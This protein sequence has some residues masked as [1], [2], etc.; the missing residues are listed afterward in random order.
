M[1]KFYVNVFI[2]AFFPFFL[3]AQTS[4]LQPDSTKYHHTDAIFQSLKKVCAADNNSNDLKL[5]F[6]FYHKN[7]L[8][9]TLQGAWT[10]GTTIYIREN[11]YDICKNSINPDGALALI[12]A[13]EMVHCIKKHTGQTII[14][15]TD[16]ANNITQE[17]L[18]ITQTHEEEADI[19]GYLYARIAGYAP[20]TD[21]K[22]IIEILYKKYN[23]P[24]KSPTHPPLQKRIALAMQDYAAAEE[25]YYQYEHGLIAYILSDY[26]TAVQNFH[27]IANT[28]KITAPEVLNNE[29]VGI[30]AALC[31]SKESA[32]YQQFLTNLQ[33]DSFLKNAKQH[34]TP[35][36]STRG[37]TEVYKELYKFL[38]PKYNSYSDSLRYKYLL[39][40][41]DSLLQKASNM[42]P[43]NKTIIQNKKVL[44]S[45]KQPIYTIKNDTNIIGVKP[46]KAPNLINIDEKYLNNLYDINDCT[47]ILLREDFKY[48]IINNEIIK[49][50]TNNITI[51]LTD[52][53]YT[54]NILTDIKIGDNYTM[55]EDKYGKTDIKIVTNVFTFLHYANSKVI[56]KVNN[57]S[58]NII[59]IVLY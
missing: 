10:N 32:T 28:Y 50:K 26:L 54:K 15:N 53:R 41:A 46:K 1:L 25:A 31:I 45:M 49:L 33:L 58:K 55:I 43:Q 19:L 13:H 27:H 38:R 57:E 20:S 40:Y 21:G 42:S 56:F 51:L 35:T 6:M 14:C 30:L 23:L 34:Y 36:E 39:R 2:I 18:T 16:T 52:T 17:K 29:A 24:N 47:P 3:N 59:S 7:D 22:Q 44:D 37:N 4:E 11:C 48:K 5:E 12:I 8:F 9:P